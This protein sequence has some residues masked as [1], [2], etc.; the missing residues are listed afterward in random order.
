[1]RGKITKLVSSVMVLSIALP[2]IA[3][4]AT[5]YSSDITLPRTNSWKTVVRH[6][7][8][9]QQQT[10]V[11]NNAHDVLGK[12]VLAANGSDLSNYYTHPAEGKD[13]YGTIATHNTGTNVGDNIQG[14]FKTTWDNYR[15]TTATISWAP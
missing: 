7:T 1:M 13:G 14:E 3:S 6:A 15:T 10:R 4:A 11:T 9:S 8:G 5:W 2:M 12:I